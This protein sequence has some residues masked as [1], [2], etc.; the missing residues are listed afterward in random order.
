MLRGL[1]L[2]F[3]ASWSLYCLSFDLRILNTPLVSLKFCA[4]AFEI[5]NCTMGA[6]YG[7]GPAYLN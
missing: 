5:L 1:L 7:T 4:V 6:K 2:V 3:L